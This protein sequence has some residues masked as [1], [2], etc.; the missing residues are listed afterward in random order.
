M[1][2]VA[3]PTEEQT[4]AAPLLHSMSNASIASSAS[5]AS[6][7]QADQRV[8]EQFRANAIHAT[9]PRA[10]EQPLPQDGHATQLKGVDQPMDVDSMPVST[11]VQC[12]EDGDRGS[13]AL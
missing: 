5:S 1:T 7:N 3:S 11:P 9:Q 13:L 8:E 4:G 2:G 6:L 12:S 10:E